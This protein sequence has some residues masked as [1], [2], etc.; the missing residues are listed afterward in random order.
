MMSQKNKHHLNIT[1]LPNAILQ[2]AY[3]RLYISL[4]ML[5][6]AALMKIHLNDGLKY[7]IIPFSNGAGQQS[8]YESILPPESSLTESLFLQA[9]RN[10]LNIIDIISSPEVVVG[11]NKHHLKMLQDQ[12]IL[13]SFDTW[14]DMDRQLHSQFINNPF[15]VDPTCLTY[16]H[17]FEW[18]CMDAFLVQVEKLKQHSWGHGSVCGGHQESNHILS[19]SSRH[20]PYDKDSAHSK[21]NDSFWDG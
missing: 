10:W 12:K 20:G 8:L 13:T 6:T 19:G 9:Y 3:L 7:H 17:L 15:I 2:M 18:A 14:R 1:K 4:S 16:T 21:W 5:T 11:W